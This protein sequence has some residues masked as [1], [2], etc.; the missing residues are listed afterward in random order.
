[1][2]DTIPED[3]E[4][5]K[6]KEISVAEFFEK[7]RHLLGFSNKQ[8]AIITC[9]KE[10]VDN[11]LDSAEEERIFPKIHINI[12]KTRKDRLRFVVK[13]N[14][15]GIA[16]EQIPKVFGKL[17]YGSKFHRLK[18]SRGQQGMGISASGYTLN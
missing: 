8:K 14:A 10:A 3:P 1:M 11:S 2:G 16:K 6:H 9:I 4:E 5:S 12:E 18:E 17:L 15:T 13:D 7:N